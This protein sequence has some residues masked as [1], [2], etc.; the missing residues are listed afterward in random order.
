MADIIIPHG[1][2][3]EST[4]TVTA[5]DTASKYGSGLVE[6]FATP[7]MVALMENAC[8][9]AVLPYLPEGFS[10][11]GV[12]ISVSH[13]KATPMGKVVKCMATLTKVDGRK[14]D[15]E[16]VASDEEGLIGKGTHSRY[17]INIEKFMEKL[18]K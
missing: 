7:A 17:I 2:T 1:I 11:V 14:L 10:S 6:V 9:N 3:F 18:K 5:N 13:V 15:F 4:Q 8:L 16:V 12:D